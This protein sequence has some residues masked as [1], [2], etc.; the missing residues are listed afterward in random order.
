MERKN[1]ISDFLMKNKLENVPVEWMPSDA[2]F[3]HYARIKTP[4]KNYILM[5]APKPEN[6]KQFVV[7]DE[8]LV[9]NGLN[10]SKLA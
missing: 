1:L 9:K 6:P 3:R 2:S 10:V 7:V 8:I 4:E 5:D